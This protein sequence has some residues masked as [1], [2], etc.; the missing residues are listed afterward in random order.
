[1]RLDDGHGVLRRLAAD[2]NLCP[3]GWSAEEVD[4]V[5]RVR[6]CADAAEVDDDVLSLRSLRLSRAPQHGPRAYSTPLRNGLNLLV[7]FASGPAGITARF[8]LHNETDGLT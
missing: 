8:T 6:Q 4:V 1:V 5:H 3:E 2:A 7:V